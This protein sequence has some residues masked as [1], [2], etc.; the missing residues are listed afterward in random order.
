MLLEDTTVTSD[1]STDSDLLVAE[2]SIRIPTE[3]GF[4]GLWPHS[5]CLSYV[6]QHY[7]TANFEQNTRPVR[8]FPTGLSSIPAAAGTLGM[9]AF[10]CSLTPPS[11]SNSLPLIPTHL[12]Y[13]VVDADQMHRV[14]D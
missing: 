1:A 11:L 10:L 4:L 9:L 3:W 12:W 5:A 8:P 7:T 13:D 2:L 6:S 14:V